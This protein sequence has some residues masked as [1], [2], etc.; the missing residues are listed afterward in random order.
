[1]TGGIVWRRPRGLASSQH[2]TDGDEVLAR[3]WSD[4]DF[5]RAIWLPVPPEPVMLLSASGMML[6]GRVFHRRADSLT[7]AIVVPLAALDPAELD[8]LVVEY[9]NPC[10]RVRF[11]GIL[12]AIDGG[13]CIRI[14]VEA[15]ELISV[16]QQR[17]YIRADLECPVVVDTAD[18]CLRTHTVDL[19][20]GGMRL[21]DHG[22]LVRNET[23]RFALEAFSDAHPIVGTAR[24]VRFDAEARPALEFVSIGV[25]DRWRLVRLTLDLQRDRI[26]PAPKTA[27]SA[28]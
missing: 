25:A 10:G 17:A 5:D 7:I 14:N 4:Y 12:T 1:M 19:S 9:T 20:G 2:G 22:S 11:T 23:V 16:V 6:P 18:G 28:P 15:P 26:G 27:L 13:D 8:G 24:T 21:A 3:P